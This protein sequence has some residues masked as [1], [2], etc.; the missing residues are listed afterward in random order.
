MY[1]DALSSESDNVLQWSVKTLDGDKQYG[2]TPAGAPPAVPASSDR[3]NFKGA[4]TLTIAA[5]LAQSYAIY[6]DQP[7]SGT[8][9]CSAL[10]ST[11][12]PL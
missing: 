5:A 1:A 3:H 11:A 7:S 2:K 10:G 4:A 6:N 12:A 9:G 8:R